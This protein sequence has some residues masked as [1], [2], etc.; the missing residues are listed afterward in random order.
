MKQAVFLD[1][2]GVI[3][4]LVFFP[5]HGIID[6]PLNPKQFKLLPGAAEGIRALNDLGFKV[7][8][9]SNQPTVAKGK[10]TQALFEKIRLKM[11]KLLEKEGAHV[12]AEYYCMH[13]PNAAVQELKMK[14]DCRKPEPGLI[15]KAAKDF[16]LDLSKSYLVGDGITD[17][18]AG[19]A[20]GCKTILIGEL[21]CDLC[22]R[23]EDEN[24]K[25]DVIA[26]SLL[27]ASKLIG[28]ELK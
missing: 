18:K 28:K 15:L 8:V 5:E 13:H 3:N 20:V 14:C 23:M 24:V 16:D 1:R 19:N 9:V 22:R 6:S 10:S 25:P 12:D 21:K 7:I 4:E 11:K 2:D 26:R 27:E 17:I